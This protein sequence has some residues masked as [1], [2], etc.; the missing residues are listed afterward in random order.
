MYNE[1]IENIFVKSKIKILSGRENLK[2][3]SNHENSNA[4]KIIVKWQK[5]KKIAEFNYKILHN[6]LINNVYLCKWISTI[7]KECS[8]CND[9]EDIIHMLYECEV[10]TDIWNALGKHRNLSIKKNKKKQ[11]F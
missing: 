10:N 2:N 6:S 9:S 7:K 1:H 11:H 3:T 8:Y 4:F 5:N